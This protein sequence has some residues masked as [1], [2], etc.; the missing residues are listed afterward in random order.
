MGQPSAYVIQH[1]VTGGVYIGSTEDFYSRRH[2]HLS[3]LKYNKHPNPHLQRAY[4]FDD[5]LTFTEHPVNNRDEAYDLEQ[6]LVNDAIARG[7]T[8]F[9]IGVQNVRSPG[10]GVI[11]SEEHRRKIGDANRGRYVGIPLSPEHRQKIATANLGKTASDETRRNQSLAHQGQ[12]PGNA[13]SV[14]IS[15]VT[16]S[17]YQRAA[18]ALGMK[19]ATVR[20]RCLST[21][22][23]FI[24]WTNQPSE[25]T[26]V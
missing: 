13:I 15:G 9:N 8:V 17:S 12:I 18:D 26:E 1:N 5:G 6:R 3:N 22:P 10:L 7:M 25:L 16:Y 4:S 11:P 2:Q 24:D 19:M 20:Q 14:T 23:R 21:S